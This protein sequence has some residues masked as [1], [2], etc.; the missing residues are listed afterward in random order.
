VDRARALY[1]RYVG[2]HSTSTAWLK[3]AKFETRSG[4][5]SA[6]RSVFERALEVCIHIIYFFCIKLLAGYLKI[7]FLNF[8]L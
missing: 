6:A 7:G 8:C 5:L 1:E 2:C 4:S 3:F